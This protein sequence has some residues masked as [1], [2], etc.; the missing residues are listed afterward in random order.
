MVEQ[1]RAVPKVRV[2]EINQICAVVRDARTAMRAY[3]ETAGIGP[4]R[5]YTVS[6]EEFEQ[7]SYR[8]GAGRFK[9]LMALADLGNVQFELIQPLE[10]DSIYSDFLA[11]HGEG[12]QHLATRV[13]DMGKAVEEASANGVAVVQA[14][15]H[16]RGRP[17]GGGFA[18]LDTEEALHVTLE[19]IGPAAGQRPEPDEVYP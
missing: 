1:E 16:R 12:I 18:Y 8:G 6:S 5:L 17:K 10:G 4:W 13:P 7:A 14:G 9:F 3:W 2:A 11:R 19:L 15:L